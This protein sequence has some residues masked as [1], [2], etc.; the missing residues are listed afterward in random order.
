MVFTA[1][2][3]DHALVRLCKRMKRWSILQLRGKWDGLCH[4]VVIAVLFSFELLSIFMTL[5]DDRIFMIIA[6]IVQEKV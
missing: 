4:M 2:T 1:I 5:Y 6:L 3:E